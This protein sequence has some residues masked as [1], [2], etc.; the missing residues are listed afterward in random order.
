MFRTDERQSLCDLLAAPDGYRIHS[1]LVMTYSVDFTA[2][3][4]LLAGLG[5]QPVASGAEQDVT[6]VARAIFGLKRRVV[7]FANKA[8]IH[9]GQ[10]TKA[11]RLFSLYDRFMVPVTTEDFAFHP[12]I[13]LARFTPS[14]GERISPRFRLVC[15]SRNLT[16]ANTWECGVTLDGAPAGRTGE[17]GPEV[18]RYIRA[19]MRQTGHAGRLAGKLAREVSGVRFEEPT[20]K[21]KLAFVGQH[22]SGRSLWTDV[23]SR[24]GPGLI[25]L[26]E[27]QRFRD[28]IQAPDFDKP[29]HI[30]SDWFFADSSPAAKWRTRRAACPPLLLLSATP[31]RLYTTSREEAQGSSHHDQLFEVLRFVAATDEQDP[32][33]QKLARH[34]AEFTEKLPKV[35]AGQV[36][37]ELLVL[38]HSLEDRLKRLMCRTERNWYYADDRKGVVDASGGHVG[39]TLPSEGEARELHGLLD[40][41]VSS[42]SESTPRVMD[43]WKSSPAC[44]SFMS[45]DYQARRRLKTARLPIREKERSLLVGRGQLP[46]LIGRNLKFRTLTERVFGGRDESAEPGESV[47]PFLWCAPTYRY[48]DDG[49]FDRR[50]GDRADPS[51]FLV[52]S[53]W[54]FVPGAIAGILSREVERQIGCAD[55]KKWQEGEPLRF[56]KDRSLGV[57]DICFPSVALASMVDPLEIAARL[58][59]S[60][61]GGTHVTLAEVRRLGAERFRQSLDACGVSVKETG[62]GESSYGARDSLWRVIARLDARYEPTGA[63]L[64]GQGRREWLPGMIRKHRIK[65]GHHTNVTESKNARRT[66]G[67]YA[68]WLTG[69][70]HGDAEPISITPHQFD[71]VLDIALF[72][73]A[74][75]ILRAVTRAVPGAGGELR[76]WYP[77]ALDAGLVGVRHY[78]NRAYSRAVVDRVTKKRR[79]YG[80]RVLNY[81]GSAQMQAVLDEFA[82]LLAGAG[83]ADTPHG[84]AKAA[85]ATMTHVLTMGTGRPTVRVVQG[86][87]T[88]STSIR[89]H[90]A[91][92]F[93]EESSEQ[94]GGKAR[95]RHTRE[96]FNSPFWPFVLATTS[97]GQEGLDFHW[98]CRDVA[99][100]NLPSNPVDLEQREGR[101][102]RRDGLVIRR[103]IAHDFPLRSLRLGDEE[104]LWAAVFRT[105]NDR[106]AGQHHARHGLFPRW[107]YEARKRGVQ[108]EQIR[109]HLFHYA[110]SRDRR[111]YKRLTQDLALYRH[112]FGQANQEELMA[113]LRQEA[114]SNVDVKRLEP[115]MLNLAPFE[116]GYAWKAAL[117]EAARHLQAG[118]N[119]WLSTLVRDVRRLLVRQSE[120]LGKAPRDAARRI[121]DYVMC[122]VTEPEG[123]NKKVPPLLTE[124]TAA[125]VYLRNPFDDRF[126]IHRSVGFQDDAKVLLSVAKQLPVVH[127][128]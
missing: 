67:Q 76:D 60:A 29:P 37:D 121:C 93:A 117:G 21:W 111:R 48:W 113:R 86:R 18:T 127:S 81:C 61:R 118:E 97:V 63:P 11:R 24:S 54:R 65:S 16:T 105:L 42:A 98:Y 89:S 92:A 95:R 90:F 72:S 70:L 128:N 34:L 28:V 26:D 27:F 126:D 120:A 46:S 68:A 87:R 125:L 39:D 62:R 96:A 88:V 7:V 56:R 74:V 57:F 85:L 77:H 80:E 41:L 22:P 35:A 78:F 30:L 115:Y 102:N 112:V 8:F 12:K 82:F 45:T 99:H 40:L 4:A 119:R 14:K 3:T 94:G 106:M 38:K 43:Y 59:R 71:R 13:W 19:L 1:L 108:V 122:P 50:N 20:G 6:D 31:Y 33:L 66:L 2:L 79:G 116:P 49:I 64:D 101:V 84:I 9:P 100:W 53:H 75:S 32:D 15:S 51:K 114:G 124:A 47:W 52:F 103:S 91:L 83:G 123:A 36:A 107:L 17:I 44:L 110:G 58:H 109:R 104:S 23:P 55:E 69:E 25:V 10:V 5:P 73:P